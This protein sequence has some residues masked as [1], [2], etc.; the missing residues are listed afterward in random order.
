MTDPIFIQTSIVVKLVFF[1]EGCL[2]VLQPNLWLNFNKD[3]FLR[4]FYR[5]RCQ[6][7]PFNKFV[8]GDFRGVGDVVFSRD[9]TH[10]KYFFNVLKSLSLC[11]DL[12][13]KNMLKVSFRYNESLNSFGDIDL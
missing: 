4:P 10:Y 3:S 9:A 5:F 11:S 12:S 7:G 1:W 6:S 2:E 13:V 8:R